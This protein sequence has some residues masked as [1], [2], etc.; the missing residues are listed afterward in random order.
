MD[1]NKPFFKI[2]VGKFDREESICYAE[3]M[4]ELQ[5][6]TLGVFSRDLTASR[7]ISLDMWAWRP[8][9]VEPLTKSAYDLYVKSCKACGVTPEK[10]SFANGQLDLF[11]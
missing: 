5:G 8:E 4:V 7:Y 1:T 10:Y 11:E 3:A 2:K 9:W 6:K